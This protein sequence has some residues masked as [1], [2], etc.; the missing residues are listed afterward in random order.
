MRTYSKWMLLAV[1]A[2]SLAACNK[3]DE[4]DHQDENELITTVKITLKNN[5][6][7]AD[8]SVAIWKDLDGEG[9][10]NPVIDTLK[11]KAN[12]VYVGKIQLLDESKNPVDNITEEVAEEAVEHLFVYKPSAGLGLSIERTDKDKNN[13]PIGIA[14]KFTSTAA[15]TGNLE[16]ILRHQP[17]TKDGTETPGS[18]DVD[19]FFPTK[20]Q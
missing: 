19:V 5:Q 20:V 2:G 13:L 7:A 10:Q 3:D 15:A 9:G 12:T 6:N 14:T 8:S 1:V 18:S 11:L 16:I 4:D 17:G